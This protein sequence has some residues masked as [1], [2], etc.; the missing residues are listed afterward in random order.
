MKRIFYVLAMVS[1]VSCNPPDEPDYVYDTMVKDLP[2]NLYKINSEFDDYNSNLPYPASRLG[3]YF[4][5]NRNSNGGDFDIIYKNLDISYHEEDSAYNIGQVED[6]YDRYQSKLLP[7]LQTEYDELGPYSFFGSSG[8]DYFFYADNESG[9]FDIKFIWNYRGD[10][11]SYNAKEILNGPH[12]ALSI[13]SGSDD[14]YPSINQDQTEM[15]FCSNRENNFYSIYKTSL[16]YQGPLYEY[17]VGEI[18]NEILVDTILSS[19]Y[20][21]KCPSI[22]GNILVFASDRE[23]GFGGFDLYYSLY[24]DGNWTIPENFGAKI[25]SASDEY[26]PITV[27]LVGNPDLMIFSSNRPGGKGG[28]DLYVVDINNVLNRDLLY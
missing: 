22:N 10:F 20:N 1:I 2:V 8:L 19:E 9:N 18:S 6:S 15:Y 3:I 23:G 27:S 24:E 25:N 4:S 16:E 26:R 5:S 21:D 13:N 14:F 7:L 12:A 11:G 28:F 17:F